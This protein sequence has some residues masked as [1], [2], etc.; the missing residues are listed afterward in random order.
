MIAAT[1]CNKTICMYERMV[2][3]FLMF[4]V[5]LYHK[6]RHSSY[7]NNFNRNVSFYQLFAG[8]GKNI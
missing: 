6:L 8:G 7:K 4:K 5:W 1:T 3:D 2:H